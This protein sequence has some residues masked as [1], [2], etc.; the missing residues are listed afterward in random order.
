MK[1][2][3][4]IAALAAPAAAASAASDVTLA[5]EVFVEHIKAGP[6]GKPVVVRERPTVVTPGDKL[7][8]ELSYKNQGA[9]P[10]TGFALTDP[11]PASVV[12]TGGESP[13]AVFSV[14]GGKTWGPLESLKVAQ[15]DG[16]SRP[17]G[18][19][20][21]T[22]IRWSFSQAIAAGASGK[23]SFRGVVK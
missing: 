21:V 16:T 10:A 23:L 1:I 3:L 4:A 18:R 8:F 14:D 7:V 12:F 5:S 15:P 11:I 9:Q 13:N 17:A 2:W 6:D 20:D 22:H 19:S